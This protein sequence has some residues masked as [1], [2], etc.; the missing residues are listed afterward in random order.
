MLPTIPKFPNF[1]YRIHGNEAISEI[2]ATTIAL[3]LQLT[4]LTLVV[5]K[6]GEFKLSSVANCT[7]R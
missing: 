6:G 3:R 4:L 1:L 2:I 7:Q 5:P